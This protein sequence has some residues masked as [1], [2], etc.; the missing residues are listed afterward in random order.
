MSNPQYSANSTNLL[1][2]DMYCDTD[3]KLTLTFRNV[4]TGE[5]YVCN[6]AVVG[7]VWQSSVFESKSFKTSGGAPMSDF[8]GDLKF[9]VTCSADFAVNNIMWL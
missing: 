7:G 4:S 6:V 2:I 9:T 8:T 5:D 1:S 3:S